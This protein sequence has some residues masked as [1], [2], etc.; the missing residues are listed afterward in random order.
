MAFFGSAR[1]IITGEQENIDSVLALLRSFPHLQLCDVNTQEKREN[2]YASVKAAAVSLAE[3]VGALD[4]K[5]KRVKSDPND[6]EAGEHRAEA[7]RKWLEITESEYKSLLA[8]K[9]TLESEI[10]ECVSAQKILARFEGKKID[11]GRY[12]DADN[13][14]LRIGRM[15]KKAYKRLLKICRDGGEIL[16]P[17]ASVKKKIAYVMYLCPIGVAESKSA[18]LAEL[19]FEFLAPF[20]IKRT[21]DES[22]EEIN[23]S[24]S[25]NNAALQD[26]QERIKEFCSENREVIF[27]ILEHLELS[28]KH[29]DDREKADIKYGVFTAE[30]LLRGTSRRK[31]AKKLTALGCKVMPK[32]DMRR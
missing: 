23:R 9:A 1:I 28:E 24:I 12:K 20:Y 15:P 17:F 2:P 25:E 31:I 32:K 4:K 8:E 10:A 26:L 30:V 14:A 13:F 16:L 19:G 3:A 27:Q 11:F 29:F 6:T 7:Y 21:P 5:A 18:F 22:L